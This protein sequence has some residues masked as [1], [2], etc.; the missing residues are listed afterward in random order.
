MQSG[1]T[2]V[3]KKCGM[4]Y[5]LEAMR[6]MAGA[7]STPE[8]STLAQR[9]GE[10]DR[11]AL[12]IYLSDLRTMETLVVLSQQKIEEGE[13]KLEQQQTQIR[14]IKWPEL[15]S[16]EYPDKSNYNEGP[17]WLIIGITLS[18]L[19]VLMLLSMGNNDT[20]VDI[21]LTFGFMFGVGSTLYG[22]WAVN[23]DKESY[24]KACQEVEDR[25]ASNAEAMA[26]YN[27]RLETEQSKYNQLNQLFH[28]RK[29]D[30][31]ADIAKI[32]SMLQK[33]Y[34]IN[35]IPAQFRSIEGVYY[36]YD[37][38]SSSNQTLS[39]ALMQANL[40]SIKQKLDQMIELQSVQI[41]QQARTNARLANITQQNQHILNAA[42][43]AAENTADAAKYARMAAI[44]SELTK[45]LAAKQLA[46]QR[47][48]FWLK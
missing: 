12:L 34:S 20:F 43:A 39:E 5:D 21:C 15:Y 31:D 48:D 28:D 2:G 7:L 45:R 26:A 30:I 18:I 46:Y 17:F 38:L 1:Q 29:K 44:N 32:T 37:Y 24:K 35:I 47:V 9:S 11:D 27:I 19:N 4:E 42:E 13:A 36:L 23:R 14:E 6:A 3:C 33:A 16:E 40:E 41:I 10:M 8:R 25:K 22:I